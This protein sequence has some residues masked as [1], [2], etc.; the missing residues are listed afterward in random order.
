MNSWV[1]QS[2][3]YDFRPSPER[4]LFFKWQHFLFCSNENPAITA[5]LYLTNLLEEIKHDLTQ[6]KSVNKKMLTLS[7]IQNLLQKEE[8]RVALISLFEQ[9]Y[10]SQEAIK[11]FLS[12]V[13]DYDSSDGEKKGEKIAPSDSNHCNSSS[14]HT[15]TYVIAAHM[16]LELNGEEAQ[17]GALVRDTPALKRFI[18]EKFGAVKLSA[19]LADMKDF[20]Y[21]A[22]LSGK[23]KEGAKGQLRPQLMQIISNASIFGDAIAQHAQKIWN[24]YFLE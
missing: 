12:E 2:F 13:T 9:Q 4:Y 21:K 14:L 16:Y 11:P 22:P 23:N 10:P 7:L 24:E 18:E 17:Y 6:Y 3:L 15:R 8:S 19:R 20:S 5:S 1:W